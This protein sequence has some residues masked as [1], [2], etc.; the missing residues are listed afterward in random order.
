MTFSRL[1]LEQ[2]GKF[3][4]SEQFALEDTWRYAQTGHPAP[5]GPSGGW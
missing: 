5:A 2:W 1:Q 3:V 4:V